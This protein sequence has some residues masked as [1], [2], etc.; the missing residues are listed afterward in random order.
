MSKIAISGAFEGLDTTLIDFTV[1]SGLTTGRGC[2]VYPS[3][4]LTNYVQAS[5]EL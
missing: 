5:A 1:A 4:A 2:V 3:N